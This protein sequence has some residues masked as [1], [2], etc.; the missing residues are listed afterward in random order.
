M[1]YIFCNQGY[2]LRFIPIAVASAKRNGS[3]L[4]LVF[5][6]T[7]PLPKHPLKKLLSRVRHFLERLT[8]QK[9]LT[10]RYGA[11]VIIT[12]NVNSRAF[13]KKIL[14]DSHGVITGFNQI[15]FK[16]SIDEFET[17]VNFHP[18][19]LPLYRGP[20]PSYWC[21]KNSERQTG[22]T[23][24]KVSEKIDEGEILFQ[25]AV[26]IDDISDEASLDQ[27]IAKSAGPAL[28]MYIDHLTDKQP[29]ER[30]LVNADEVYINHVT[31]VSFP[32]K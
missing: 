26:E 4:N 15:F 31:Y 7:R 20:T 30:K 6:D 5:S 25:E 13:R 3:P 2:G 23:L 27:K 12:E 9:Q 21:I 24:H 1:I 32:G 19:I 11:P 16:D 28:S 14:P 22:F 29:W 10:E 17:L 8:L 18:S